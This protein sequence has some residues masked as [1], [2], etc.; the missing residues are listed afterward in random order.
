MTKY[1]LHAALIL[2]ISISL[3]ISFS[4]PASAK[5]YKWV[6]KNGTT[7]YGEAIPPEYADKD[8]AELNK[9]GRIVNKQEVLTPEEL[10]AERSN[11]EQ[12]A[13]RKRKEEQAAVEKKR[14]DKA[15]VDTYSNVNEI[16]LARKRNLQQIE[17]RINGINA[18]IKMANANLLGLQKEAEA[19]SSKNKKIP[20]SLQE[21][22]DEAQARLDKLNR[23]LEKPMAE[24]AAME[25]RYD[26][27]K[28]RYK[29]LTG[30]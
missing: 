21:D 29:E 15:L 13:A 5:L 19:L 24:K 4:Q 18:N 3:G 2:G 30:K 23:D 7:H 10:R 11:K 8:R 26:A 22:L 28:I 25:A 6:D 9:A 14:R 17:L 1:K 20:P 12:E 16:D 27:D